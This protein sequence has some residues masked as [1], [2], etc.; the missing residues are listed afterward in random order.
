MH[1]RRMAGARRGSLI[2]ATW[3][4]GIGFLFIAKQAAAWSW[5]EAWPL[6]I[7]LFG[8]V[9]FVSA[10][11]RGQF[12][13]TGICIGGGVA[14]NRALRAEIQRVCDE[15]GRRA[16]L[17]ASAMCTDNAAMVAAAAWWRIGVDGPTSLDCSAYPGLRL[18]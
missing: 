2:A 5:G 10:A 18:R 11:L 17:P 13:A 14:A 3:L 15:D 7:I 9:A 1:D 8:V 6:W 4:I 16:L 12:G